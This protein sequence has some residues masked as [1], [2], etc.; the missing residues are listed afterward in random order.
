ML[1]KLTKERIT[2]PF[3]SNNATTFTVNV[4]LVLTLRRLLAIQIDFSTF[5]AILKSLALYIWSLLP[6]K[7]CTADDLYVVSRIY[8]LKGK[9]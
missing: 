5:A 1:L 2:S 8:I 6:I 9:N 3:F 7:Y 4:K